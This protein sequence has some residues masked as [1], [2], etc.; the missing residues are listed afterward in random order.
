VSGQPVGP[1]QIIEMRKIPEKSEDLFNTSAEARNHAI[2]CLKLTLAAQTLQIKL[3]CAFWPLLILL[4]DKLL[5]SFSAFLPSHNSVCMLCHKCASGW[6]C[7]FN[8]VKCVNNTFSYFSNNI[9]LFSQWNKQLIT[10]KY[11]NIIQLLEFGMYYLLWDPI[12]L[13]CQWN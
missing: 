4:L 3:Q 13:R 12:L 1:S 2:S 11:E 9:Y 6:F 10:S 8:L 5:T 7:W